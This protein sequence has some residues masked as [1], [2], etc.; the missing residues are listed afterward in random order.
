M[1]YLFKVIDAC[2]GAIAEAETD[3]GN[4]VYNNNNNDIYIEWTLSS[5]DAFKRCM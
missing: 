4:K 1:T 2:L 5:K 3:K